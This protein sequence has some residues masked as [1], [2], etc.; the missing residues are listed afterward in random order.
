MST[1]G[2][3]RLRSKDERQGLN[4]HS[5]RGKEGSIWGPKRQ[6][7]IPDIWPGVSSSLDSR[8]HLRK[9]VSLVAITSPKR[10]IPS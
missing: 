2:L 3:K 7:P 1:K 9:E 8:C 5:N 10:A 4:T 6:R